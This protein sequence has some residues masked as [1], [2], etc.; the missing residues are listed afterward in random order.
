MLYPA[1]LRG[2]GGGALAPALTS[3]LFAFGVSAGGTQL[4]VVAAALPSLFG[5]GGQLA[6]IAGQGWFLGHG[7]LRR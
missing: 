3:I 5:F 2:P 7:V 4:G 6:L 1:E